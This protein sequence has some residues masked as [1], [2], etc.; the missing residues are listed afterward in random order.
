MSYPL[1]QYVPMKLNLL[2]WLQQDEGQTLA[3]TGRSA[4]VRPDYQ[5]MKSNLPRL[6]ALLNAV[7]PGG[8]DDFASHLIFDDI[9]KTIHYTAA[10]RMRRGKRRAPATPARSAA[11]A[12][13][14]TLAC[15]A[16]VTRLRDEKHLSFEAIASLLLN[17]S[18]TIRQ[19]YAQAQRRAPHGR[20]N[21]AD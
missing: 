9:K 7:F 12:S 18:A 14:A 10:A 15:E 17:K 5:R 2:T 21:R 11:T 16:L 20:T 3:A 13:P 1:C 6:V 19:V 8:G 4:G